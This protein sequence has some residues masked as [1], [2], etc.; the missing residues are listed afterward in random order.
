MKNDVRDFFELSLFKRLCSCRR[1]SCYRRSPRRR[2]PPKSG[3]YL[4]LGPLGRH[5]ACADNSNIRI[6]NDRPLE[7]WC[8]Q[9]RWR[10]RRED[11]TGSRRLR[12][13]STGSQSRGRDSSRF[14]GIA[15][16]REGAPRNSSSG[17]YD[18]V[19][20]YSCIERRLSYYSLTTTYYYIHHIFYPTPTQAELPF[21]RIILFWS[22]TCLKEIASDSLVWTTLAIYVGIRIY[23]NF[24]DHVPES[25]DLLSK[26]NVGILG[27]F[28]SFFLVLFVNQTNGR[29]LEMYGFSKA[30][31]NCVNCLELT[32]WFTSCDICQG[33]NPRP[34]FVPFFLAHYVVLW[35]DSGYRWT[36]KDTDAGGGGR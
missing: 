32:L 30:V 29:F 19:F 9:R 12:R 21:W 20:L 26:T 3:H 31:S 24:I 17:E 10:L 23:A 34:L 22:G 4:W 25:V 2:W 33:T 36:C 1:E 18:I 16:D 8:S 27:G 13:V 35:K 15:S 5:L 6:N 7:V 11:S 28:L 14:Q